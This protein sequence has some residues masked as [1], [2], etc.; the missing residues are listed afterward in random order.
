MTDGAPR[1]SRQVRPATGA[2]VPE[3]VAVLADAFMDSGVFRW[4]QPDDTVRQR[5]LPVMF[6]GL[7][8]RVHPVERGAELLTDGDRVVGAAVWA[9]PGRW[10]APW[11]SQILA[12]PALLRVLDRESL[13]TFSSRGNAVDHAAHAVHPKAPHW[14]LA[15]LG[16]SPTAQGTGV[17][18]A[19]VRSG[20][21]RCHGQAVP[22]Y[23]ECETHLVPYYERLGFHSIHDLEMPDDAPDQVG[24]WHDHRG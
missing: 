16:V 12:F 8:R 19:L 3:M 10:K 4:L 5:M 1:S 18:S 22:A 23:L 17:G 2:D 24:M 14:Y 7:L 9:P 15:G 20:L 13:K 21:D 11:W 6:T